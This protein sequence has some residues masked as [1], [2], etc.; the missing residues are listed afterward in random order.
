MYLQIYESIMLWVKYDLI[1][2]LQFLPELIKYVNTLLIPISYFNDYI[3]CEE[4]LR[5][6][7]HSNTIKNIFLYS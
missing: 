7:C 1:N 3:E 5:T 4:I 6:H 2:R